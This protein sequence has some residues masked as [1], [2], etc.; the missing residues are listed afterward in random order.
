MATLQRRTHHVN[1]ADTLKAKVHA[2]VGE[3]NNHVLYRLIVIVRVDEIGRAH[4]TSQFEF[5][6]IGINSQNTPGFCLHRAL[7]HR[8]ANT[9]Q[10]KYGYGIAFL[11]FRGVMD[12]SDTGGH[13]TSQQ[14]HFIQRSLRVNLRQRDLCANGIFAEGTGTHIVIN[15]LAVI[16]EARCAI[17][18]QTFALCRPHGLTQVSFT[19]FTELALA[20]LCGVQRDHMIARF[21]AGDAFP[22]FNHN[23]AA[24]MAQY[25]REHA[26]R[27]VA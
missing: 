2:T 18:H 20:A 16:R 22:H 21:Q 6:R 8:Q 1:V 12:R 14:T 25:R 27:I 4:F 10:T 7:N 19:R 5:L 24:F 13:A 9:A 11:H 26:F 15:R 23:A 3:L 17:R